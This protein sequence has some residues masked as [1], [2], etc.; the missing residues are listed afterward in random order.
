MVDATNNTA[1]LG[2]VE[3]ISEDPSILYRDSAKSK[4]TLLAI[5]Q[6]SFSSCKYQLKV[7]N[8]CQHYRLE[9]KRK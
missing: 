8:K 9:G 4:E 1:Y 5:L 7:A 3:M 6:S 2:F